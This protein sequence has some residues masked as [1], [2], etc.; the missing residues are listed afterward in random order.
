[1]LNKL[2]FFLL[3]IFLSACQNSK[4][5]AACE[6][7]I[8]EQAQLIEAFKF[9]IDSINQKLLEK[10]QHVQRLQLVKYTLSKEREGRENIDSL[11]KIIK[12]AT[13][14]E[15][16]YKENSVYHDLIKEEN[17]SNEIQIALPGVFYKNEV[18]DTLQNLDWFGLYKDGDKFRTKKTDITIEP[19]IWGYM[20]TPKKDAKKITATS[21]ET[22]MLLI[23]GLENLKEGFI[24]SVP[25]K[26][27]YISLGQSRSIKFNEKHTRLYA[28]GTFLQNG[29]LEEY[30]LKISASKKISDQTSPKYF[31]QVF[32]GTQENCGK[33][34]ILWTGD[35]D[36]DGELDLI[37]E[38]DCSDAGSYKIELFLSSKAEKGKL[39][40]KAAEWS[41]IVHRGC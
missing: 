25:A 23:S 38:L 18:A 41:N 8:T 7:T 19:A 24:E 6:N 16:K 40:K 32:A 31:S 5:K 3:L 2:L 28:F 27:N 22:P 4:F 17:L 39:L 35:I 29:Y 34:T 33:Y 21:V 26:K 12:Q 14:R 30:L 11:K 36:Q 37:L 20:E 10:Q 13:K 1:M 9:E 15:E